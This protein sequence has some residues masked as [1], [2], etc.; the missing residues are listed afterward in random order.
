MVGVRLLTGEPAVDLFAALHVPAVVHFLPHL[1]LAPAQENSAVMGESAARPLGDRGAARGI[2]HVEERLVMV[3]PEFRGAEVRTV[4]VTRHG[5]AI[6]PD[7]QI[8]ARLVF[9]LKS[10][11][12]GLR[13]QKDKKGGECFH[14]QRGEKKGRSENRHRK[15]SGCIWVIHQP[16]PALA[17]SGWE[18]YKSDS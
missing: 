17:K 15:K 14:G 2:H 11:G 4:H 8:F 7:L 12:K 9:Q 18:R 1:Q 3:V 16:P 5:P 6:L 13:S 10:G